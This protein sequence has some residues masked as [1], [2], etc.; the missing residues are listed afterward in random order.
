MNGT[1]LVNLLSSSY[2]VS[3]SIRAAV[4]YAEAHEPLIDHLRR[5]PEVKLTFYGRLSATE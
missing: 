2:P 1:F 5:H 4:A 3:K